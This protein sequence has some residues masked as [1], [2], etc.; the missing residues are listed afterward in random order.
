MFREDE[1]VA[2][3]KASESSAAGDSADAAAAALV[4]ELEQL[5]V[6]STAI[7]HPTCHTV[8]ILPAYSACMHVV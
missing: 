2:E 4:A 8:Q 6:M 5:Q 7:Q 1:G 3:S